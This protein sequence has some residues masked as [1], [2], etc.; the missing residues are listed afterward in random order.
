MTKLD[1][2]TDQA[3]IDIRWSNSFNGINII[4]GAAFGAV[5][6]HVD[7]KAVDFATAIFIIPIL[8]YLSLSVIYLASYRFS[9]ASAWPDIGKRVGMYVVTMVLSGAASWQLLGAWWLLP[10]VLASW[11]F[12][13]Q[14]AKRLLNGFIAHD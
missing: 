6:S 14:V 2:V 9:S 1:P 13:V 5:I 8:L 7:W 3:A 4:H 11:L 10:I 12:C